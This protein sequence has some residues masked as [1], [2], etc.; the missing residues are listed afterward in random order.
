V[1]SGGRKSIRYVTASGLARSLGKSRKTVQAWCSAGR[2]RAHRKGGS[3]RIPSTEA[4]RLA[5]ILSTSKRGEPP[6]KVST[7]AKSRAAWDA[8]L[9]EDLA[10]RNRG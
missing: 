2:V 4:G 7:L 5:A 10:E 1:K 6:P 3:W 9:D 8:A